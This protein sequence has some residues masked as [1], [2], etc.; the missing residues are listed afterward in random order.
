MWS[1][2]FVCIVCKL[3]Y[4]QNS[5]ARIICNVK[6]HDPISSVLNPCLPSVLKVIYLAFVFVDYY[7]SVLLYFYSPVSVGDRVCLESR[8]R[9]VTTTGLARSSVY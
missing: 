5:A 1:S 6:K 9:A 4:V 2:T 7:L 8:V 3:Q